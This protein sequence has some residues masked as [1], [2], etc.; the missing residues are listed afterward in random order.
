MTWRR[1]TAI[2]IVAAVALLI[3][4]DVLVAVTPEPGDTISEVLRDAMHAHPVI[5]FALGV[6]CGHLVWAQRAPKQRPQCWDCSD[7]VDPQLILCPSCQHEMD[8]WANCGGVVEA[9]STTED[10]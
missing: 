3:G 6:L 7:E 2:V 10:A 9:L 1:I 4:Y 5:A 8:E